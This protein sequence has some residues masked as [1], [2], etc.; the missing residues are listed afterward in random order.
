[1]ALSQAKAPDGGLGS[2][3]AAGQP[4]AGREHRSLPV[5]ADILLAELAALGITM[6]AAV[7][8]SYFAGPL[9]LLESGEAQ[10]MRYVAAAN[11][12]A[13]IA[14]AAGAA[15]A[16][17]RAAV[18]AQNSGFGNMINP[19]TSLVLPYRL[20]VAVL[21]SMRGWPATGSGEQQH[22]WMGRVTRDWLR[23]LE[24]P[25]WL[26]TADG[27]PLAEAITRAG[28]ALSERRPAFLLFGR[29][30]IGDVPDGRARTRAGCTRA[31]LITAL[32]AE[33]TDQLIV[34]TTGYLSRELFALGDRPGNF[35]MQ[36]SMGHA[37]SLALG[38]A[39]TR[40][41]RRLVI[42]DGDGAVLMH[43]GSLAAVGHF[44]PANLTHIVFDNASYES[45]GG[46]LTAASRADLLAA[47]QACG[48][49]RT[50][51]IS[52]A[53]ELHQ[54]L[55][56]ALADAGPVM[57]VVTGAPAPM[58]RE[59][60][61]STMALPDIA[62]RFTSSLTRPT[63]TPARAGQ[64][65]AGIGSDIGTA[66]AGLRPLPGHPAAYFGRGAVR[67]LPG[68]L[69]AMRS[70]RVLVVHGRTS[71]ARCGAA[72]VI[73]ALSRRFAVGRFASMGPNPTVDHLAAGLA[74]AR[75]FGPDAVIGI[76]GGSAMDLAKAIAVVSPQDAD[77]LTC[78]RDPAAI[79]RPRPWL[80]LLPTT[81]GSGS[82]LTRFA[83]IYAGHSKCSLDAQQVLADTVLVD[84][85]LS[86]SVPPATA[87]AAGAD[88]LSQAVESYWAVAA[89]HES[90]NLAMQAM[91][92]LLPALAVASR[93]RSGD[94]ALHDG[95]ALGAALAGAA[96]NQTRTT[97]AHALSYALTAHCQVP[98]GLAVALHMS[99]LIGHNA[100][101]TASD[102]EHPGGPATVRAL[103]DD[104]QRACADATGQRIES[105]LG[106]LLAAGGYPRDLAGLGLPA[107][108]WLARWAEPLTSARARNNPRQVRRQDVLNALAGQ[109]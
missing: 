95:L 37:V 7:P 80:V 92:A 59:R 14:L 49:R 25:H 39:L 1:M 93:E 21:M 48:Y 27:T 10:G 76:G 61:S 54:A 15:L 96:I 40:P 89:T 38:A 33:V 86:A 63:R 69:A 19:L 4:E 31:E 57:V 17:E 11:E 77:P 108:V 88:A 28:Q 26:V 23:T 94:P 78:L 66:V 104:V 34:S 44:R 75:D 74:A 82:E 60:A 20:P 102:T 29:G 16:G 45:T 24:V 98:H 68:I 90:K 32:L 101:A 47:G 50:I 56:S 30:V 53:A 42:L 83:T 41:D 22:Y 52:S 81:C 6:V 73:D 72:P 105:L 103:V 84:P 3:H 85:C 43:L 2:E 9:R 8:C 109:N 107:D 5:P 35:Y 87:A 55:R 13:A 106:R 46:Q 64:D 97:A 58:H 79:T 65:A 91:A 12:G 71:L 99:W 62:A 36:G 100:G 70:S 67:Y 18:I 51:A